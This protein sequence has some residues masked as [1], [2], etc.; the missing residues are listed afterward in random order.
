MD[1]TQNDVAGGPLTVSGGLWGVWP[2]AWMRGGK[3]AQMH[4]ISA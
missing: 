1:C 2:D 3:D 4:A